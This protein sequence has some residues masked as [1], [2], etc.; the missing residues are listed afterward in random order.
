MPAAEFI[1]YFLMLHRT[2]KHHV[3]RGKADFPQMFDRWKPNGFIAG[4]VKTRRSLRDN[5]ARVIRG[6]NSLV[7]VKTLPT[8]FQAAFRFMSRHVIRCNVYLSFFS[9]DP[10]HTHSLPR[11]NMN[12]ANRGRP[13]EEEEAAERQKKFEKKKK[14]EKEVHLDRIRCT[15]FSPSTFARNYI[16]SRP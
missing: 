1:R 8:R 11:V 9:A 7:H 10:D 5:E 13:R 16:R 4:E 3:V 14:K 2:W 6:G 12:E 15:R